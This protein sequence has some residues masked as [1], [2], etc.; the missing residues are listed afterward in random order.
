LATY[1]KDEDNPEKFGIILDSIIR[2]YDPVIKDLSLWEGPMAYQLVGEV[3]AHQ[4]YDGY[5]V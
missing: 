4:G 2:S 5:R 3:M 1:P